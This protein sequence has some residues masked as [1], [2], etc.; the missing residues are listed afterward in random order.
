MRVL[1]TGHRGYIGVVMVPLLKSAGYDVV[2]LDTD[3]YRN[4]TFGNGY[5]R[6]HKEIIKDVRD[7]TKADIEGIDAIVHLAALSNDVL[8]DID[9]DLTYEINHLAS[10]RLAELAK[11]TGVRRFVFASSCSMYGASENTTGDI[12][13]LDESA[14]FNPVTAYAKSKVLVEQDVSAMAGEGFSPTFMRNATAY[15]SS[16]RIRFDLVVNNLCAWAYTTGKV[17][18][19]S[20][21]TPWRPLV[22]IEDI[23]KAVLAVLSSPVDKVHNEAF[24]VGRDDQN[25]Q[26]REV[27]KIVREVVPNCDLS[28]ADGAEA[29]VRNYRVNFEKYH[30]TFPDFPLTWTVPEG[31]RALYQF[32][33]EHSLSGS[34]YEGSRYKRI[35]QLKELLS[36]GELGDDLRWN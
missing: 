26:I 18:M 24:N 5:E 3:L 10:V 23:S 30:S 2:G 8:G 21:G 15:G 6:P 13:V 33:D 32:Y 14:T 25:Y 7:V 11:S 4:S 29:D 1:V 22:H 19:K 16:P 31:V 9:Q 28:F 36:N 12:P 27:A 35:G 34:E 20:D 17:M